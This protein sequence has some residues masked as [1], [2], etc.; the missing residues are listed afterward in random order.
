MKEMGQI[1]INTENILPI[2][3][4]WLYSDRDI[5]IR[6]LISNAADAMHKLQ[7][8]MILGEVHAQVDEPKITIEVDKR[9]ATISIEDTGLGMTVDE[10]KKYINQVAFSGLKDFVEKYKGKADEDQIIGHFGLGFY[11][12]FIAAD[13]VEIDTLS[14]QQGVQAVHWESTGDTN[15]TITESKRT[16]VGTKVTLHISEDSK[17][18]LDTFKVKSVVQKYCAFLKYPIYVQNELCNDTQPLWVKSPSELKDEQYLAFFKKLFPMSSEPLFW[19]HLNVDYPFNLKGILYFPKVENDIEMLKGSIKIFCNQVYV[20]EN[21]LELIPEYLTLLKGA[22]D[23]PD[24]PLNVS[25]S[26]LQKTDIVPKISQYIVKKVADK[27]IGLFKTDF[28]NY[29][30]F[31]KDIHPFIK[32]GMIQDSNF[33]EKMKDYVIFECTDDSV[34][35]CQ[36][37]LDKYGSKTEHKIIYINDKL[38]QSHYKSMFQN[39]GIH[40]LIADTFIDKHFVPFMEML[41]SRKFVFLR[42]DSIDASK[43]IIDTTSPKS[44]II[45]PKDNKTSAQ[46]IEDLFKR[47]FKDKNPSL[48]IKIEK[49]TGHIPAVFIQDENLRRLRDFNKFSNHADLFSDTKIDD[50]Y[51]L[52]INEV[53]PTIKNLLNLSETFNKEQEVNLMISHIVDLAKLQQGKFSL[54]D[55]Q[56]FMDRSLQILERF[57]QA[58]V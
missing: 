52:V 47:F 13:K 33:A 7:K 58:S 25:R 51:T 44:S 11:S 37:Y 35:T 46:K 15:Y 53:S 42:V 20:D 18:F 21:N 8:L 2:I 49:L 56:G 4:K 40:M 3:K 41:S 50:T 23:C 31:W 43:Y 9:A 19:I 57:G 14:Y 1:S 36:E 16:K 45:D 48:K 55:I 10:V 27:L 28:D 24:L 22:I 29:K 54:D 32:F 6:E 26:A 17:E 5:F 39:V 38:T 34:L 12:S 30:K